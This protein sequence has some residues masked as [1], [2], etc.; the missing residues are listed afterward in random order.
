MTAITPKG[1]TKDLPTKKIPEGYE[2]MYAPLEVGPHKIKVEY[3]NRE[4]PKSP[5]PVEVQ[6]KSKDKPKETPA[7]VKGLETRKSY[8]L[9]FMFVI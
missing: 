3:A 5:Y 2:V 6:P 8:R 9:R 4:I 1:D 7:T